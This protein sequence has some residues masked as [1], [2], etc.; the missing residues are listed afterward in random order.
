MIRKFLTVSL[1]LALSRAGVSYQGLYAGEEAS[2]VG[3]QKQEREVVH[4]DMQEVSWWDLPIDKF[5]TS[6]TSTN[7]FVD[8]GS[9]TFW[10]DDI[11]SKLGDFLE[12][13][14][15]SAEE[16][17]AVF[18]E[19]T[20]EDLVAPKNM[21]ANLKKLKNFYET[22]W[23]PF[24]KAYYPR[25][26]D[27]MSQIRQLKPYDRAVFDMNYHLSRM[28]GR[29]KEPFEV[30]NRKIYIQN[31]ALEKLKSI[32]AYVETEPL[33]RATPSF[34]KTKSG[35]CNK[36]LADIEFHAQAGPVTRLLT[37]VKSFF[38]R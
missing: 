8:L 38:S 12:K 10:L 21:L 24:F 16:R 36:D 32:M 13:F 5:Y 22:E 33:F 11:M 17:L 28:M 3:E 7:Y 18:E 4:G 2:Q 29:V 37:W 26:H 27:A 14:D 6:S 34:K 31:D 30:I 19:R 23:T 20:K 1:V 15:G 9:D 35:I 25:L